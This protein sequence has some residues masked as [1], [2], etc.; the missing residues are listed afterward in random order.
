M[1]STGADAFAFNFAAA[2]AADT[3]APEVTI[4]P[5]APTAPSMAAAA[6]DTAP[7]G[8]EDEVILAPALLGGVGPTPPVGS[9]DVA[10]QTEAHVFITNF[11]Q[12]AN[13]EQL[14]AALGA[15]SAAD[16]IRSLY[17]HAVLLVR[18]FADDEPPMG[19]SERAGRHLQEG[20]DAACQWA[21]APPG[22]RRRRLGRVRLRRPR[23]ARRGGGGGGTAKRPTR[24]KRL[25]PASGAHFPDKE[26]LLGLQGATADS[27]DEARFLER[28]VATARP[29]SR[30]TPSQWASSFGR[31]RPVC[32]AGCARKEGQC[33]RPISYPP[34]APGRGSSGALPCPLCGHVLLGGRP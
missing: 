22:R 3:A 28:R 31:S 10:V 21:E 24:I 15:L 32:A 4:S 18:D 25:H 19:D 16:P 14:A 12:G 11:I 5:W 23:S 13:D 6:A 7:S 26:V 27:R 1:S 29:R 9:T 2:G 17:V 30:P 34:I 33:L 20:Q 8:D